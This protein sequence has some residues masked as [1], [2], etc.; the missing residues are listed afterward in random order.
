VTVVEGGRPLVYEV[1]VHIRALMKNIPPGSDIVVQLCF[2]R[3]CTVC[4]LLMDSTIRFSVSRC[5]RIGTQGKM[6]VVL[7]TVLKPPS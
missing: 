4:E 6:G 1:L 3:G 7:Y 5:P 2:K